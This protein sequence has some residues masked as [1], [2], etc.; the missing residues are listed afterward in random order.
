VYVRLHAVLNLWTRISVFAI[1]F[2]RRLLAL[3]VVNP[4]FQA[5]F[6]SLL[7]LASFWYNPDNVLVLIHWSLFYYFSAL[8]QQFYSFKSIFIP[9]ENLAIRW[10]AIS[11]FCTTGTW[12][13]DNKNAHTFDFLWIFTPG[14][15]MHTLFP[16]MC[17][18]LH[19]RNSL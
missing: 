1:K 4:E 3:G 5:I 7:K 13:I 12:W 11:A 15:C 17:L 16:C 6:W 10:I 19:F 14:H 9:V 8:S 18:L 2:V